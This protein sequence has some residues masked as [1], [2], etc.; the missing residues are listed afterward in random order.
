MKS[1]S[2]QSTERAV[3]CSL[4]KPANKL[5]WKRAPRLAWCSVPPGAECIPKI[6]MNTEPNIKYA[7]P[8]ND[9]SAGQQTVAEIKSGN[10]SPE[11]SPRT[12][13]A[14]LREAILNAMYYWVQ[15]RF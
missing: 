11:S 14:E 8:P 10:T 9:L 3:S 15:S 12:E 2:W 7:E 5:H 1:K 4:T 6:D 13:T